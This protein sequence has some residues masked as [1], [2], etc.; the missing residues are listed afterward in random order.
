MNGG[1]N[2]SENPKTY[3]AETENIILADAVREGYIFEGWYTDAEFNEQVTQI[4]KGSTGNITLYAKWKAD[5]VNGLDLPNFDQTYSGIDG[6]KLSSKA[7]GK[8]KLLVFFMWDQDAGK[9][10]MQ[11]ITGI[12]DS[13][14]GVDVYAI[15]MTQ[16]GTLDLAGE[17]KKYKEAYGCDE[18]KFAYAD[19]NSPANYDKGDAYQQAAG[20]SGMYLPL[21]CYI[22]KDN[23]LQW[24]SDHEQT[25]GQILA[26]LEKYCGYITEN[27][28]EGK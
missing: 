17:T 5:G 11:N 4:A 19:W 23:R 24:V 27:K 20:L 7:D 15:D 3:T 28:P 14:S 13:L 25:S 18:I 16:S 1:T 9:E 22:D 26:N 10:T 21:M 8:P 2:S 12:I 6:T